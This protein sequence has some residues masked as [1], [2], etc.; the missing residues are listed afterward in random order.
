MKIS[1]WVRYCNVIDEI[2]YLKVL[3]DRRASSRPDPRTSRN[4]PPDSLALG[5][6]PCLNICTLLYQQPKYQV[7]LTI[8]RGCCWVV[9]KS[10]VLD[11]MDREVEL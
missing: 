5:L 8:Q 3:I 6:P 10:G 2:R 4:E 1:L 9:I 11:S 7:N